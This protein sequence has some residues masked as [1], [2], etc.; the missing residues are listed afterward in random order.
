MQM[1]ITIKCVILKNGTCALESQG[2][3]SDHRGGTRLSPQS[4]PLWHE[5][6]RKPMHC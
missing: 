4:L 3:G 6:G 5:A 1:A 2:Q